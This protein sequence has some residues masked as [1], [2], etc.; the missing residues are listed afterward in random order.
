ML[1]PHQTIE[2]VIFARELVLGM[3]GIF[4]F[5]TQQMFMKGGKT[6]YF[7]HRRVAS[8]ACTNSRR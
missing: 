2:S 8:D 6:H 4:F 3:A 7:L 5:F 1:S